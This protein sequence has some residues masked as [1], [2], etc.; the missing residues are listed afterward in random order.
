MATTSST[1]SSPSEAAS[2][3]R[4]AMAKT[5]LFG[6]LAAG[7]G[8]W[9]LVAVVAIVRKPD[10]ETLL[11]G[12]FGG[13]FMGL[14]VMAAGA[15]LGMRIVSPPAAPAPADTA[16]GAALEVTLKDVLAELEA[17]RLEIVRKVNARAV[18]RVFHRCAR[19]T[20]TV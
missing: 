15:W 20:I 19:A 8:V 14:F 5:V 2:R 13:L 10:L 12:V 6:A 9:I 18:V 11:G 1:G 3:Q 17:T 4:T 16:R 7:V